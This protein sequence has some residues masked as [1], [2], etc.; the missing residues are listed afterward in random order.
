MILKFED[1]LNE[2]VSYQKKQSMTPEEIF[3]S[4]RKE[5]TSILF[6]GDARRNGNLENIANNFRRYCPGIDEDVKVYTC[7]FEAKNAI[8]VEDMS[9]LNALINIILDGTYSGRK[10]QIVLFLDRY[11]NEFEQIEK[12]GL[13]DSINYIDADM[14][15]TDNF[16][17]PR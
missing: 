17:L 1:F 5:G 4:F 2:R 6:I 7:G 3:N 13:L 15:D 14:L 16:N 12:E 10:A 9:E 8:E 11:C